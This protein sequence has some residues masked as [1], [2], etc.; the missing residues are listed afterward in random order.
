[1]V[2][3]A[4]VELVNCTT[5]VH[6][7]GTCLATNC[8]DLRIE[9]CWV[10]HS[11]DDG[12]GF[13]QDP[14]VPMRRVSIIFR[15]NLIRDSFGGKAHCGAADG[16]WNGKPSQVLIEN[17][18]F[19][20]ANLY[21]TD[22]NNSPSSTT[23][24]GPPHNFIFRGN[25]IK[26]LTKI[27]PTSDGSPIGRGLNIVLKS[28]NSFD[29]TCRIENNTFIRDP[30][31]QG[32]RLQDAYSWAAVGGAGKPGWVPG[33]DQQGGGFFDEFGWKPTYTIDLASVGVFLSGTNSGSVTHSG[34]TYQGSGWTGKL[35]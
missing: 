18:V 19:E 30:S 14:N 22:F 35:S 15:H 20:S 2:N 6:S 11:G 29:S 5:Y 34:N 3:A 16:T 26:N 32:K 21:G 12:L 25:T 31:I 13:H 33:V 9:N 24:H 23:F 4:F 10:N 7:R 17:N 28:T 27:A 8:R 1:M